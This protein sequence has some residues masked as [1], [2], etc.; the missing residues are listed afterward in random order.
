M[1]NLKF[2]E[3]KIFSLKDFLNEFSMIN[4]NNNNNLNYFNNE[5]NEIE[6]ENNS[7]KI[8]NKLLK[9]E[10]ENLKKENNEMHFELEKIKKK[11]ETDIEISKLTLNE[12][13]KKINFLL[14][15]NSN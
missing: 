11:F 15:Y 2:K 3:S 8:E 13:N 5:N 4:N 14:E 9:N 6:K 7:L 10:N 1:S 12:K